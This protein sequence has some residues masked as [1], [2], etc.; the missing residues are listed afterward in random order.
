MEILPVV[1]VMSLN[2][3]LTF[4]FNCHTAKCVWGMVAKCFN[5]NVVPGNLHQ[6]WFWLDSNLGDAKEIST[7][8]AVPFVGQFGKPGIMCAFKTLWSALLLKLCVMLVH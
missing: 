8:C 1:S 3:P 5:S 7:V 6:C 4:F 2:R